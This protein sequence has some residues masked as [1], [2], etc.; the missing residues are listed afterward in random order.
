MP[1]LTLTAEESEEYSRIMSDVETRIN[2]SIPK[3]ITGELSMDTWD[4]FVEELIAMGL[5][6]A[7]QIEQAAFDRFMAR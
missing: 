1:T 6:E 4:A 3:F 7:Q 2:E 5:P